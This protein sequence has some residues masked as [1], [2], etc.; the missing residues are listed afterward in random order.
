MYCPRPLD[1]YHGLN[2]QH[3]IVFQDPDVHPPG[4]KPVLKDVV[5]LCLHV[6]DE[7]YRL[8]ERGYDGLVIGA[9]SHLRPIHTYHAVPLPC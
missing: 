1:V 5:T 7:Y 2:E 9:E 8:A 3:R 6:S 4:Q